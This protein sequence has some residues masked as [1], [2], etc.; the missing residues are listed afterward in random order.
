MDSSNKG[1]PKG[2]NVYN[3]RRQPEERHTRYVEALTGALHHT[4]S[5]VLEPPKKYSAVEYTQENS[6]NG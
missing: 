4:V 5:A 2:Q 1:V 3:L 6:S